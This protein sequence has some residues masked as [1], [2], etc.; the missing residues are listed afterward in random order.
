MSNI[1][2]YSLDIK[3]VALPEPVVALPEP[4]V[5]SAKHTAVKNICLK[6]IDGKSVSFINNYFFSNRAQFVALIKLYRES[7]N[8]I[9][10][11]KQ[12]VDIYFNEAIK[13]DVK[14][15]NCAAILT[16]NQGK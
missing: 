5:A 6:H 16:S 12:R 11:N 4:V 1:Y 2:K 9:Y 14:T 10:Y 15:H 3:I 13:F 8:I 7:L